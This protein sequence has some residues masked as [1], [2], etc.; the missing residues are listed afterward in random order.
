MNELEQTCEP[1][2]LQSHCPELFDLLGCEENLDIIRRQSSVYDEGKEARGQIEVTYP[3][4]YH[5]PS[6]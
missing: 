4:A 2:R 5:P 6:F 3:I 1:T